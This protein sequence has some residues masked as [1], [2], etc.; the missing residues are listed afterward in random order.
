M[1]N[2]KNYI[3]FLPEEAIVEVS[4][5]QEKLIT[6]I[7]EHISKYSGFALFIDYGELKPCYQD[8]L[9]AV[10]NHKY[11]NIFESPGKA[12]LTSHINF[13]NLA[14]IAQKYNCDCFGRT[15]GEFLISL[16]ILERGKALNSHSIDRLVNPQAMGTLFKMMGISRCGI[17]PFNFNK[18]NKI[19]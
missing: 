18:E 13:Y 2:I 10:K 3:N 6:N 14:K 12:D 1:N 9:Q 16:G 7:S 19:I 17:T 4:P 15:Q 8:S 5:T 11:A